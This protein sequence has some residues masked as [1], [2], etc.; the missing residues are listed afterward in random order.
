MTD[1]L[2]Y[3]TLNGW[4][5]GALSFAQPSATGGWQMIRANASSWLD[6]GFLEG[7]WVEV[8]SSAGAGACAAG[9]TGRFKIAIIRGDNATKDEKVELRSYVDLDGIFHLVDDLSAFAAGTYLVRRIA[10]VAHFSTTDWFLEQQVELQAD[11]GYVVPIS[12]QGVKVFPVSTHGLCKL[13]RPARRRGRRLGRRPLAEA[14]PEAAGREG[15]PAVQDR[16]AAAGVQA[17][18]RP[19][20]LQR[21]LAGGRRG[22]R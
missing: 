2:S 18:R 21:R 7:Q 15:R 19:E 13:Q 8:C 16:H 14:R 10:P 9:S 22:A 20:H 6:D 4:F 17:D 1:T 3:L 11:V 12:R 5:E